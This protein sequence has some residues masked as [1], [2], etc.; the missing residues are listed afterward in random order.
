MADQK[1]ASSSSDEV[2]DSSAISPWDEELDLP[3]S[4]ADKSQIIGSLDGDQQSDMIQNQVPFNVPEEIIEDKVGKKIS[5]DEIKG[6]DI[7]KYFAPQ[8]VDKDEKSDLQSIKNNKNDALIGKESLALKT[9]TLSSSDSG[10]KTDNIQQ[11]LPKNQGPSDEQKLNQTSMAEQPYSVKE[12]QKPKEDGVLE[13]ISKTDEIDPF[14]SPIVMPETAS[15]KQNAVNVKPNQSVAEKSNALPDNLSAKIE[16]GQDNNV[17]DFSTAKKFDSLYQNSI[18]DAP[19]QQAVSEQE[20]ESNDQTDT[21]KA[22]QEKP[23]KKK[24]SFLGVAKLFNRVKQ[25]RVAKN[26][27]NA[28]SDG[29][30]NINSRSRNDNNNAVI[31]KPKE[32]KLSP[33]ISIGF[34]IAMVFVA[35]IYLSE[36][37][38]I[39]LGIENIYGAVGLEKIWG[40]L[41]KSAEQ[42][43]GMAIVKNKEHLSFK[44]QGSITVTADKTKN[45]PIVSPLLSYGKNIELQADFSTAF[46]EKAT[47]AQ[48]DYY[49]DYYSDYYSDDSAS[50]STT[51]TDTDTSV[52]SDD[53]ARDSSDSS[54][55]DIESP[56]PTEVDDT[57]YSN[58]ANDSYVLHEPTLKQLEFEVEG[59]SN[60][61][62]IS[63]LITLKPLVGA[64]KYI[65]LLNSAGNI[66]V[67]SDQIRYDDLA[68]NGKW[69]QYQLNN[70][71]S[72]NNFSELFNINFDSGFSIIGRRTGNEKIS[73][74]R[75]YKYKIDNLEIGDAFEQIGIPQESVNSISGNVWIGI[76]DHLIHKVSLE[77]IPSIA[78]SLTRI[79]IELN[80]LEYD[81]SNEI[82]VPSLSDVIKADKAQ[83]QEDIAETDSND[84]SAQ[85]NN[86]DTDQNIVADSTQRIANDAKRHQDLEN[87]KTALQSYKAVNGRYPKSENFININSISNVVKQAIVPNYITSMPTDPKSSESW[88]YGYKSDGYSFTLSARF[89]NINDKE[90]T[91][92]GNVYLHYVWN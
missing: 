10:Q 57:D 66:Y 26:E 41:P 17:S 68:E 63:S 51:E 87:I 77:I 1:T 72:G 67:K 3:E 42:A 37:G 81:V 4:A 35:L 14:A 44:Y 7:P 54:S 2:K 91:K 31:K 30:S 23:S 71:P 50:T 59:K 62:S 24:P 15:N 16:K 78:S 12:S 56:D 73:N 27:T 89:E 86:D 92:F 40:G 79:Q 5:A 19:V 43:L 18:E 65:N 88:W 29:S 45:S 58:D 13:L 38:A 52:Y 6:S 53:S 76:K 60:S 20:S 8:E 74:I 32:I 69:L 39:S 80:F 83:S 11:G 34:S 46:A 47:L 61:E 21:P 84:G 48:Y 55:S 9:Q 70:L 75:C 64:E 22:E 36:I 33:K 85:I 49:D 90:V 28:L 25:K 82:I